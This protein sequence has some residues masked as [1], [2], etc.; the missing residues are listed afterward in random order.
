M[1]GIP[2]EYSRQALVVWW[3]LLIVIAREGNPDRDNLNDV[4]GLNTSNNPYSDVKIVASTSTSPRNDN[5]GT[6][7]P[8]H[9][10]KS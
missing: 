1:Y 2:W 5:A 4:A 9:I 7:S 3:V 10:L 6:I 8:P